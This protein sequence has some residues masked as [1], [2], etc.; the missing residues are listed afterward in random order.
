[1]NREEPDNP[2]D[3]EESNE[4][5]GIPSII[6]IRNTVIKLRNGKASGIYN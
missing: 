4:I 2:V 1:L 5:F 6:K 3:D